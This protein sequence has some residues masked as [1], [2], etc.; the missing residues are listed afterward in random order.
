MQVFEFVT[1]NEIVDYLIIVPS[2]NKRM[3]LKF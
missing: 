1:C 3:Y 2:L